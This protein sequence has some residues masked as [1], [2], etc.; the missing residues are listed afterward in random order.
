LK[1]PPNGY[2][3][4]GKPKPDDVRIQPFKVNISTAQID[5]LKKR[6]NAARIGHKELEDVGDWSYGIR[7]GQLEKWRKYWAEQ[8]NFDGFQTELNKFPQFTTELEGLKV[9]HIPL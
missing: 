3:G 1:I 2:F 5:E 9:G 7:L 4:L 6:L 8:F